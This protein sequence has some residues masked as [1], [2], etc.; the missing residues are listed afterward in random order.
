MAGF[1]LQGYCHGPSVHG[2]YLTARPLAGY[3]K[4]FGYDCL[5]MFP[6]PGYSS[7]PGLTEAHPGLHAV[8]STQLS[9]C[10]SPSL[11]QE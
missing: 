2:S 1:G 8:L 3:G 5:S 6:P 11:A 10:Q 4:V 9:T 7:I